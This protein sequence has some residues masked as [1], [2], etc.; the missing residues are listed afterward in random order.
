MHVLSLTLLAS[1]LAPQDPRNATIQLP[2]GHQVT[3]AMLADINID[4]RVDLVLACYDPATDKRSL[5]VH[6]RQAKRGTAFTSAPSRPPF[7]IDP[8]VVAFTFLDCSEEAGQELVLL[9]PE[10][11]AAV[12]SKSNGAPDYRQL[13]RHQLLWPA[14]NSSA[15]VPLRSAA[16]DFDGDGQGDLLLPK[17]NGWSVLFQD[18]KDGAPTFDRTQTITLPKWEN[19]LTKAVQ[20]RGITSEGN[21]FNMRFGGGRPSGIGGMLVRTSTR[22]P[23]CK[24]LD[25]DEN[26]LLDLV[27]YRNDSMHAAMQNKAGALTP[28]DQ[29]LPL[30][31]NRLKAFDPAFNV[32]WADFNGDRRTDLLLTSSAQRDGEVEVRV[33]VFLANQDGGWPDKPDSRLRMQ[34]LARPPQLIDVNADGIDDLV[35]VTL[36]TS[37][38]ANLTSP[39]T[40]S[41]DAQLTMYRNDGGAFVT[42]SLLS[43]QLPLVTDSRLRKPFLVVRPGRRGRPG[44]VLLHTNGH[45]ER[46]FLNLKGKQ[47][48]M[49]KADARAPVPKRASI[50]VAD[51]IGDDIL[52]LTDGEVRHV[53]FRR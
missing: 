27:M 53:S 50:L 28:T 6:L 5:R 32:Q 49:A 31:P 15:V 8:D 16:I 24:V 48:T 21:A 23:Q 25:L 30:S 4:E 36:R 47:L 33:D 39:K 13:A 10:L 51:L 29:Q 38:M 52:I 42:P 34:Q 22:T 26:G 41:F 2:K 3:G 14:A 45:I 18:R 20:S 43:K 35:C 1:F 46:R 40:A 17:P 12:I 37:A 11:V 9:T 44:D 7:A 19:S